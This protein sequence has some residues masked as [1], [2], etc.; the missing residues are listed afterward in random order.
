[1]TQVVQTHHHFDHSAGLRAAVAEGLTIISRRGNEGIFREMA[2]RP[3]RLFPDA[4]ER[5]P[6]AL[7]F[8]PVDGR[9]VRRR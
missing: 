7:K 2:E 5:H 4:L 3:A 6:T 9:R 1:V 8:I